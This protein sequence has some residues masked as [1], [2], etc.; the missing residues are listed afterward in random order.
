MSTNP[1][2][3]GDPEY[4]TKYRNVAL[5]RPASGMLALRFHTD[6]GAAHLRRHDSPLPS[7][8]TRQPRH[9]RPSANA[10][11]SPAREAGMGTRRPCPWPVP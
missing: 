4:C 8:H 9:S 3:A 2:P 11:L 5:S 7:W 6:G 1:S 10:R